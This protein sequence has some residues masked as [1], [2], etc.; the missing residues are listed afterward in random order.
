MNIF[1]YYYIKIRSIFRYLFC[2]KEKVDENII[3][4]DNYVNWNSLFQNT[5][6]RDEFNNPMK[7]DIDKIC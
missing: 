1:T 2:I 5:D 7:K 4:Q 6:Y 3:I